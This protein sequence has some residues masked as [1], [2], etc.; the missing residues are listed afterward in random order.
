MLPQGALKAT[1]NHA[2]WLL[3]WN[4]ISNEITPTL[5]L[6]IN[7]VTPPFT[8]QPP[9]HRLHKHHLL[10]PL[11]YF[12]TPPQTRQFHYL[13]Q[14]LRRRRLPRRRA[15]RQRRRRRRL[16]QRPRRSPRGIRHLHGRGLRRRRLNVPRRVRVWP[17]QRA[18]E[19]R[20]VENGGA[21]FDGERRNVVRTRRHLGGGEGA[22]PDPVLLP[23]LADFGYPLPPGPHSHPSVYG[24]LATAISGL[25]G[26]FVIRCCQMGL[27]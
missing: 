27:R 12:Q 17:G 24:V 26:P 8:V 7:A 18:G 4:L 10:T 21:A 11:R 1:K 15:N 3:H 19:L 20:E 6:T 13:P 25:L 23:G 22:E 16:W 5:P 9:V 2:L 14:L